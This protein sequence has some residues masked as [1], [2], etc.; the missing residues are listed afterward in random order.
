LLEEDGAAD[1]VDGGS[2]ERIVLGAADVEVI[3]EAVATL[4]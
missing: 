4:H 3:E 2:L 1:L